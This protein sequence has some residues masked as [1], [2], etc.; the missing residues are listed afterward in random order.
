MFD[1]I[2]VS[3]SAGS[4]LYVSAFGSTG[5]GVAPTA[6]TASQV[7]IYVLA[8]TM[9]SSPGPMP[10]ARKAKVSASKPLANPTACSASQ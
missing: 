5:T 9:T 4:I 8:G 10:S 3:I 6:D 2:A 7:A 1:V